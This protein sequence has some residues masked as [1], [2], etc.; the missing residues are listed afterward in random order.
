LEHL[1]TLRVDD[2]ALLVEHV[3][4]LEDVLAHDEVLL[5]DLLLRVLDLARE[6]R[7][8]HRLVLLDLE[9]LHDLLDA[10][11][12]E[13]PDEVVLAGQV[14]PRFAVVALTAGTS[15]EL[16]VDAA[17]LVSL[18]AEDVEAAQ[19]ADALAELDVDAASG[20]VRRDRDRVRLAGLGDDPG[21]ALVLLR[22]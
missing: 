2:G 7:G 6:D 9:P 18:G 1:P 19:F 8:L 4:V 15:A 11:A 17:G 12:G 13:Q 10:V 3:V 16:V 5:L 14:E 21:L 20:H 22:V